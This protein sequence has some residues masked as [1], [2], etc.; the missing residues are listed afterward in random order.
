M[1]AFT[2]LDINR[3]YINRTGEDTARFAAPYAEVYRCKPA[4]KTFPLRGQ[5]LTIGNGKREPWRIFSF[6]LLAQHVR[7]DFSQNT[8]TI[9]E[10]Y[11]RNYYIFFLKQPLIRIINLLRIFKISL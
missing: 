6:L 4:S 9:W 11:I 2:R 5:I 1:F 10:I 7:I 8:E 3:V